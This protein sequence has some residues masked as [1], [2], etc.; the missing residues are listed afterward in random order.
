M[1]NVQIGIERW[2]LSTP[3][4]RIRQLLT[5]T[6]PKRLTSS[7]WCMRGLVP[8]GRFHRGARIRSAHAPSA[9]SG[10]RPFLL[11]SREADPERVV[12]AFWCEIETRP[13][14]P[15]SRRC[16]QGFDRLCGRASLCGEAVSP[17]GASRSARCPAPANRSN[18]AS[19]RG[20]GNA[21][22]SYTA[23][24]GCIRLWNVLT[25]ALVASGMPR[26]PLRSS[27]ASRRRA[28]STAKDSGAVVGHRGFEIVGEAADEAVTPGVRATSRRPWPSSAPPARRYRGH[29]DDPSIG[30]QG[31]AHSSHVPCRRCGA[32]CP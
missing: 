27:S 2:R 16:R 22:R 19:H 18:A 12:A 9:Q 10:A 7:R 8:D 14:T 20:A 23:S 29:R 3:S 15:S 6:L 13:T 32:S 11:A 25:S 24:R 31:S 17:I 30:P 21:L 4:L 5:L 26:D 1:G 28:E